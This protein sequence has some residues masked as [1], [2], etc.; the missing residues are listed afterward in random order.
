MG[1]PPRR[2]HP[3]GQ[4][5]R[6]AAAL[7]GRARPR[8]PRDRGDR[9]RR[10]LQGRRPRR[11]R[12]GRSATGCA[13][14]CAAASRFWRRSIQARVVVSTVLLSAVVVSV[15]RLDPAAADPRRPG[16][17]P[18]RRRPSPRPAARPPTAEPARRGASAP[19]STP[20]ASS[21]QLVEPIIARG[22]VPR[23]RRGARRPGRRRHRR[24]STAAAP[25]HA[26]A[27]RRQR[28][29]RALVRSTSTSPAPTAWT[30]TTIRL[31]AGLGDVTTWPGIVVGSRI[32]AA[33]RRRHLRALL[34]VPDDEQEQDTL[35]AGRPRAAHRRGP[36]AGAGRRRH[37]AGHPPG[38]HP[39]PAGPPGRRAAGRRAGSR[40][41]CRSAA[42]TTSP[43]WRTSF[44]QMATSLQ[45]Q[46]RQL[47]ELSPGAAPVR[48]RRLPRAAHA[49]DH[50]ADGRRRAARRPRRLR[51]GDRP[52]RRAAAERAGPVRDAARPTCWRSAAST[53]APPCS[54]SSDVNLVDVAHRVVDVT[55]AA[56]RRSAAR[57]V[58]V[59]R[60]GRAL[61]GRG[62][63]TPGRADRAQPGHQRH[64]PRRVR[65]D[66]VI[67]VDGDD[68]GRRAR[69]ARLRRRAAPG[70]GRAGLQPVLAGRPGPGPHQR[71]HRAGAVDL[72]GGRPAARRL[73]AG[74]GRARARARS[75]GSPCPGAPATALRQSPLPLV[76]EDAG[77][78]RRPA[79]MRRDRTAARDRGRA[80]LVRRCLLALAGGCVAP[81]RRAGRSRSGRAPGERL[82]EA[83][84]D[85]TPPRPAPG[86]S[87][88]EIVARLPRRDA[89]H[90]GPDHGGRAVPH[91]RRRASV[92]PGAA[93]D[94][95]RR[96]APRRRRR[97]RRRSRST[98]ADTA[99]RAAAAGPGALAEQRVDG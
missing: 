98:D 96:R 41:G 59:A 48:L 38:R 1:L 6:P 3:A 82:D 78:R 83:R 90:P 10:R 32:A 12:H 27:R 68:A 97:R 7:Q 65:P 92:E 31:R 88:T 33:G 19:T 81:A 5:A 52:G 46:I 74:L 53:P 87:P 25:V 42:R 16:R 64:R 43:A 67:L 18:G 91:R 60:A 8:E 29:R 11:A 2:R 75:S 95:L 54:T 86:A 84:F 73:A 13:G 26:R 94:R 72:A 66:V 21:T 37:L 85:F 89:G 63:R 36:A 35:G 76:P 30:Y 15:R 62:R 22:A 70:R 40:S 23:L 99:R 39:G 9:P 69:R 47:E 17:Q 49:A 58:V 44:N 14:G 77:R 34:P 57:P 79:P 50:G 4:R 93:D 28:A 56:G 24:A 61:P 80:V 51:P 20:A 45:R 55:R 71:R